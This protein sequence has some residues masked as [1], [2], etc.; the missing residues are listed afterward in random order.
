ME[1][2]V[3][4]NWLLFTTGN[5]ICNVI[6]EYRSEEE[7][8]GPLSYSRIT[9]KANLHMVSD[10]KDISKKH[11]AYWGDLHRIQISQRGGSTD[12]LQ[13]VHSPCYVETG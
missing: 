2:L 11:C 1:G 5:P 7:T 9:E 10:W 12:Q 8:A 13:P 6:C 4:E 3:A